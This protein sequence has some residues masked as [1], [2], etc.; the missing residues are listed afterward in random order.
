MLRSAVLAAMTVMLL[1]VSAREGFRWR[2][3]VADE[4][5]RPTV[6]EASSM[7]GIAWVSNGVYWTVTDEK[8]KTVMWEMDLPVSP[9]TGKIG[10]CSLKMLSR[11]EGTVDVE[12]LVRDPFD[13]MV[14]LADERAVAI[15]KH[16]PHTGRRLDGPVALP[17]EMKNTYR[18]SGIESLTMSEDGLVMWTCAEESLRT[19][20]PRATR[21]AGSYVRLARLERKSAADPWRPAGQW[22][23]LT[24]EVVGKPWYNRK[25]EDITRSGISELCLLEDGTLL[26]LEREFSVVVIP[27]LR[28]RIY[29]TDFTDADNVLGRAS[30]A[31][32]ASPPRTVAKRLIHEITGLSMYEGMCLGPSMKDGSRLLVLVSDGDNRTLQ[33]VMTLRLSRIGANGSGGAVP[34]QGGGKGAK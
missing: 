13:G 6:A 19:D 29:E 11:P 2:I 28:C 12:G 1:P 5:C 4:I 24:D 23:Y 26:V 16:D 21:K 34:S 14:W 18:D 22:V 27:R 15:A 25:K 7:G 33:S 32:G 30:L 10:G 17:P 31:D 20:G 9:D 3:D 8:R